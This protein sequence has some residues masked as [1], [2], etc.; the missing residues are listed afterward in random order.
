M[1]WDQ[2]PPGSL[3]FSALNPLPTPI[4]VSSGASGSTAILN[5]QVRRRPRWRQ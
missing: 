1:N 3:L 5:E 4:Q 2:T